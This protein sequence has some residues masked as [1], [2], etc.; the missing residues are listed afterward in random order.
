[1]DRYSRQELFSPIGKDGQAAI[2]SASVG[3]VGCGALGSLQAEAIVRAGV[4][5]L[6]IIDR[7]FVEFSNLQRQA[8][9]SEKDAAASTPKAIAAA[10][11]LKEI[12]SEV[13]VEPVV[14]DLSS[15]RLDLLSGL[16]LVLD[17][18][19]NFQTRYLLNDYAWSKRVPWIYGACVGSSG[20]ACAFVPPD[21]PCLR[22]LFESE[23]AVGTAPTCD[24]VGIVWPAVG[25]VVSFQIAAALKILVGELLRPELLQVDMWA[26]HYH[27]VSIANAKNGD[28]ATCGTKDFPSLNSPR[29]LQT[30]LCGRKAI[31]VKPSNSS[32][33]DLVDFEKRWKAIGQVQRN[34]FLVK[35]LIQ[36]GA[37][38]SL[39]ATGTEAGPTEM[40]EIVLFSDG[41]AIIKGTAD[42][43]RARD[44]Y[45][46][47]VGM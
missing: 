38:A 37:Q 9:F 8:L 21:F 39:P 46:K 15:D 34:P 36:S 20:I 22:C 40:V 26:S 25:A 3:I 13:E 14:A 10:A 44:L 30:S 5:R 16:N 29:D 23:P 19:D 17:G 31:Q 32:T 43:V 35:L 12:N 42:P 11:R 24:T 47:Y 33:L 18:T 1:M 4:G 27:L 28:C 41:R 45:S 2:R 6:R 7:D